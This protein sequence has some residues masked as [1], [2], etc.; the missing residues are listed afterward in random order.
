MLG[1]VGGCEFVGEIGEVGK[2]QFS[3]VR[4][5]TDGEEA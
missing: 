2:G 5:V 1:G 3:W 4:F